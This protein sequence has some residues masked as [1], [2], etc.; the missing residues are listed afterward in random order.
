MCPTIGSRSKRRRWSR[1]RPMR[2]W[3]APNFPCARYMVAARLVASLARPGGN[4]TGIS[5]LSP[6]LDGKR[7]DILME[8]VPGVRRMA[9]LADSNVTPTGHIQALQEAARAR[10]VELTVFGVA[11]PQDIVP[12]I[13]SAKAAGAEAINFLASGLFFPVSR[14]PI[15]GAPAVRHRNGATCPIWVVHVAAGGAAWH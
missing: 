12:A 8:A 11:T 15:D 9:A 13:H 5:L 2:S 10:G 7:Q 3:Q 4:I 1:P 14:G 6:E